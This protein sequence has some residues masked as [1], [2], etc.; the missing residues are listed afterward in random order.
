MVVFFDID[1]TI[2][3]D[4]TQIIPESAIRAVEQL[5]K[6]G[7]LAVVN[8]GRPYSHIDPRIRKMAFAGWICGCGMEILLDGQWIA[9]HHPAPEICREVVKAARD[10]RM[11]VLY[12]AANGDLYTDGELSTH[13]ACTS[14]AARMR[15]K[16]FRVC[17]IDELPQPE[18]MKLVT[19][20]D[21][22]SRPEEFVSRV[23]GWYDCTDR[24]NTMLELVLKG[25][26]KAGGMVEFLQK[27]NLPQEET[28]AVGDSTNDLPMFG[29]ARHS[30]ALGS[31]MQELKD[32]AEYITDTVLNDGIEKAMKHF[33]L[34]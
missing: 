19:F 4:D 18:F 10:A 9:R 15:K 1:G 17:D 31:G 29:V 16:G 26:T 30:A 24:G 33:G 8:T 25:H 3:D 34:I 6:N 28:I 7:H 21:E 11:Q 27:L 20:C 2:I 22:F 23:E 14:E 13:I 32:H 12:E 5:G